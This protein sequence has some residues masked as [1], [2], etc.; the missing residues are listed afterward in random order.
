[1]QS[2]KDSYWANNASRYDKNPNKDIK[3]LLSR[4]Q[5]DIGYANRVLDIAAGTGN[6][7]LF[8]AK[9]VHH[10]DTLDI[11]TKMI[12][13]ARKNAEEA[14]IKN[15]SFH[16]QSAYELN[17]PDAV[18][19]VVV[20]LNSLHVMETPDLALNEA[21]RVIKPKGLLFVPTY[22]HAETKES[23]ANYQKWS[24][25]SGHKSYHLFTIDILCELVSNC[26]FKIKK[27][28]II[29]INH[30]KKSDVMILG[31]IVASPDTAVA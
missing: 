2:S 24:L 13:V 23:L 14:K 22:C 12:A 31:Y 25:K 11:E 10:I 3:S 19:D 6:V 7:S 30:G 1:M 18:F 4:I 26:G 28:D 8:L 16:V 5:G 20:I 29:E 17:F 9:Y 15:I 27:N 21:R